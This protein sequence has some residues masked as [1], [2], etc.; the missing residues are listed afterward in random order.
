MPS[1]DLTR[2]IAAAVD[3][4]FDAETAFLADLVRFP[5]V[6][7]V[8]A[9]CQD[10]LH[11]AMRER[12]LAVDRWTVDPEAIR[13]HP[14]F[15]P[16][17]V[18]Y[19]NTINVVGTHRPRG[20]PKGRSL[21]LNGHVDVVPPGPLDMWTSPPFEP[22]IEGGWMYGRGAG[23]MKAGVAA[24]LFA[25]D[26]LRRIGLRPAATVHV[27]CVVEEESTGNGA[28][29]A[30]LRGYRADAALIPEPT[31][32]RLTRANVGVVWFRVRVRGRPV[33]VR[34]MGAGANAIEA[35]W[36]LIGA[37]KELEARWN[38]AR[39][40][41]P[42]FATLDHPINLNVGRIAGGDWAS[43][44][45][46]WC[47]FDARVALYP[48]TRP[49]DAM[50]EIESCIADAARRDPYLANQPPEVEF[51]G[52]AAEGYVLEE[53]SEAEATLAAVHRAV[54]GGEELS[55]YVMP[56][57]LDARVFALYAGIPALVYGPRSRNIHG[58]DEA[59]ELDSVRRVTE[60]IALFM[61]DWCGVEEG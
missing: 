58:F 50:A 26:A 43:S 40:D 15:S 59:V 17:A 56:A 16:V 13:H 18:S 33:H 60:A 34:E 29:A 49:A 8:E 21:I 45:P 27:E 41:H 22:R 10:F 57:Y 51:N 32:G 5:S 7:G 44:V 53:G 14:G 35:A 55:G 52:F 12:G 1:D 20:A 28:L 3:E 19:A 47:T 9:T 2:R 36:R 25:L 24:N 30:L 48:G 11:E 31:D 37:L 23:D 38:A 54:T 6:R 39:V 61:A 42:H 46:A 4:A